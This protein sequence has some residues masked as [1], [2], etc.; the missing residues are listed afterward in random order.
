M[1]E[2]LEKAILNKN[3]AQIKEI[4]AQEPG[5]INQLNEEQIPYA[6]LAAKTGELDIIQY[7]VEYSMASMN[8]R[9]SQ[10]RGILHYAVLSGKPDAIPYLVERVGMS[11]LD[12]DR[13]L[14]T[15]FDIAHENHFSEIEQY[16]CDYYRI[17]HFWN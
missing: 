16:F 1:K 7:I 12:G 10:Y 5:I 14:V 3:L 17:S 15:P 9:D 6:F 13:N 4:L 2:R 8:T 11:A